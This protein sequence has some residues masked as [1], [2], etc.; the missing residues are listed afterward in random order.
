MSDIPLP[1]LTAAILDRIT[2]ERWFADLA[3]H[4]VIAEIR[5]KGGPEANAGEP[6]GLDEAQQMVLAGRVRAVQVRYAYAGTTWID[7]LIAVGPGAWRITR[8]DEAAV[9]RSVG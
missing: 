9:R 1:P 4:A 5:L 3:G 6:V 7:T 8:I 2:V